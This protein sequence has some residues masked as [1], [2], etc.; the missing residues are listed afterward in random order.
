MNVG[1]LIEELKRFDPAVQV[2][3]WYE[4][5]YLELEL[6]DHD[7]G[8]LLISPGEKSVEGQKYGPG[9]DDKK[10]V[11]TEHC[12]YFCC[13]K[14]D[15]S[16]CTVRKGKLKQSFEHLNTSVCHDRKPGFYDDW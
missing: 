2:A 7:Q 10:D 9:R 4:D 14:Y 6:V 5:N 3:V 1:E 11:H 8:F 12:C 16:E 15:D 13:C